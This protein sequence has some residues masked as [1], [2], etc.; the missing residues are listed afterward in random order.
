MDINTHKENDRNIKH[1]G[2]HAIQEECE[3][4]HMVDLGHGDLGDFPGQCHH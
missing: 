2:A 4:A 1:E 3:Q